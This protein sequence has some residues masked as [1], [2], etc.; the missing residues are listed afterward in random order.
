ME[1]KTVELVNLWYAFEKQHPTASLSDFFRHQIASEEHKVSTPKDI[2]PDRLPITTRLARA[3][4]RISRFHAM[5]AR[6][7]LAVLNFKN[8]D[9]FLYLN[10][11]ARMKNPKKSELI[12]ENLSEFSSGT[13]II[14]RLVR[15]GLVKESDDSEDLR[16]KRLAITPKGEKILLKCYEKMQ[17]L[18]AMALGHVS[19]QD[20]EILFSILNG[21]D[22]FH[23]SVYEKT[24]NKGIEDVRKVIE[25]KNTQG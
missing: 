20:K 24:R 6:K 12:Y 22:K 13:E 7:V 23:T 25:E 16:S 19:D 2:Y 17:D 5:Y 14:K 11:L 9:D 3:I 15:M 21:L 1:N 18:S 4:G 8:L 10:A